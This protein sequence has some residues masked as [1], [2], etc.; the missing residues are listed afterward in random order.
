MHGKLTNAL[1]FEQYWRHIH[2]ISPSD[3]SISLRCNN[4]SSFSDASTLGGL[5][6]GLESDDGSMKTKPGV[7]TWKL[8][9]KIIHKSS[10]YKEVRNHIAQI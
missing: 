2:Y 8:G 3:A 5:G 6:L 9:N 10:K 4:N 7:M 1:I